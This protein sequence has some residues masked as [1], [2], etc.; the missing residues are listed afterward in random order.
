MESRRRF[1]AEISNKYVQKMFS[2]KTKILKQA[3]PTTVEPG[4]STVTSIPT[5]MLPQR[6]PL[7]RSEDYYNPQRWIKPEKAP[8]LSREEVFKIEKDTIKGKLPLQH[9]W[10]RAARSLSTAMEPPKK[11]HIRNLPDDDYDADEH[12]GNQGNRSDAIIER[13]NMSKE[14]LE[15]FFER[16]RSVSKKRKKTSVQVVRKI[17]KLATGIEPGA[18]ELVL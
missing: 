12:L 6:K 10:S 2:R 5:E 7:P 9:G 15:S 8:T 13:K 17:P 18:D 3:N 14:F 16:A 4:P 1:K 11:S